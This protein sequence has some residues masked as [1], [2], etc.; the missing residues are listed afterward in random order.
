MVSQVIFNIDKA[1]KDEAVKKAKQQGVALS[2]IL[3][4]ATQAYVDGSLSVGVITKS[5]VNEKTIELIDKAAG[6]ISR[7]QDVSRKFHSAADAIE[8]LE[9]IK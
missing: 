4:M 2:A 7:N 5:Q 8:Y 3:K 6:D 1:L 9:S